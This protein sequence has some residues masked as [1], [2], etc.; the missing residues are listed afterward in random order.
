MPLVAADADLDAL[1]QNRN[2][3]TTVPPCDKTRDVYQNPLEMVSA[4]S[5]TEKF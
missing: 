1:T 5:H 3:G 4:R 2:N